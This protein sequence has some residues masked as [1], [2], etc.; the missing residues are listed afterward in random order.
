MEKIHSDLCGLAPILSSKKFQYYVSFIDD[1]TCYTWLYPLK[2][3]SDFYTCFLKFQAFVENHFDRKIEVFQSDG[4]GEF[5]SKEFSNHLSQCGISQQL[6]CP[7]TPEQNGLAKRKHRH[8]IVTGLTLLFH[9]NVPL[10][11]W[12]DA[13]LIAVYFINRL[14]LS[15]IGKETPY[16]KLFD[17]NP[18]YSG[19]RI[20]GSQC[21]PYLKTPALHKFSRKTTPCVFIGY[22]PLHKG[23]R[24]LDPHTHR[25]Y[26]SPHV[27]FNENHFPY[28]PQKNPM[29]TSSHDLS[30]TSF[31]NFDEWFSKKMKHVLYMKTIWMPLQNTWTLTSLIHP[32]QLSTLFPHLPHPLHPHLITT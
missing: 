5:T 1:F 21:F 10:K 15:S 22:S 4:G 13:F 27:V 23:C 28:L 9:A 7:H 14:P 17:K 24:C 2:N 3:K 11:F 30:I 12:V 6:S 29:T 26:V 31:P 19:I 25:V 18:D 20:F 16:S 8:I 32:H